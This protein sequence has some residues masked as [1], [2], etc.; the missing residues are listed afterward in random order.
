[1][2]S[3]PALALKTLCGFVVVICLSGCASK[4]EAFGFDGRALMRPIID[5]QRKADL[6]QKLAAAQAAYDLAPDSV[7]S[8]VWL[9]RRLAYLGRYQD[10]IQVYTEGL[11]KF[12]RNSRLL[13]HRGHRYVTIRKPELAV[14]DLEMA[15]Q[16]VRGLDDVIEQD[17]LP[18]AAGVPTTT[19]QFNIWYHLGLAYFLQQEWDLA[20]GAYRQCERVAVLPDAIVAIRYWLCLTLVRLG[21]M[22]RMHEA[23]ALL[24]DLPAADDLLENGDYLRLLLLF[25]DGADGTESWKSNDR[26]AVGSA[27]LGFGMANYSRYFSK[28][29][30]DPLPGF[31]ETCRRVV[32]ETGWAAFGHIAAEA[33]L[34]AEGQL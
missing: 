26:G 14:A 28:T 6:D 19:L 17:G 27:T 12:P 31:V 4:A 8:I 33:E 16:S 3:R 5:T 30:R 2:R 13:R 21:T 9:G 7:E 10:A 34:V 15:A 11:E 20:L 25:R 1:M 18:N 29:D 24:E 32:D 23:E 22:D